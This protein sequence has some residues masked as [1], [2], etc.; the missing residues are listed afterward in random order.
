MK[1]VRTGSHDASGT[2][3]YVD[4]ETLSETETAQ[5]EAFGYS[6]NG[7]ALFPFNR[8]AIASIADWKMR[9]PDRRLRFNPRAIINELLIPVLRE[10]RLQYERGEF[11]PEWFLSYDVNTLEPDVRSQV[12]ERLKNA[13]DQKRMYALLRFWAGNPKSLANAR[14]HKGVYEA[15]KLLPL[16]DSSA[17]VTSDPD[18]PSRPIAGEDTEP[19]SQQKSTPPRPTKEQEAE[20]EP[21]DIRV[22]IDRLEKWSHGQEMI[23]RDANQL[24][25]I[26]VECVLAA[27]DWDAELLRPLRKSDTGY[28]NEWVFIPASKGASQCTPANAFVTVATDE[29]FGNPD[30]QERIILALRSVVRFH[31]HKT[32]NFDRADEDFPRYANLVERLTK[33]ALS[34]FHLNYHKVD[35]DPVPCLTETLLI[36]GRL[37]SVTTAHSREDAAL[38]DALFQVPPQEPPVGE[39]AWDTLRLNCFECRPHLKEELLS[40]VAARQ[41][42]AA[43]TFAVDAHDFSM[44]F[45]V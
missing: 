21:A 13:Q 39:S 27:I 36:G 42:G 8:N 23:Q 31:Y 41:G 32:W 22:W 15:F 29:D 11:P 16:T 6:P 1:H 40:R 9:D 19:S 20:T 44:L 37:L 5:L 18:P 38:M 24:R 34:W 25:S 17:H 4:Y 10:Y 3:D 43:T 28:L 14:V 7:R 2:P 30:A 26:I 35:G 33:Q 45:V 12:R